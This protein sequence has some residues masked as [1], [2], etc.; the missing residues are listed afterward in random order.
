MKKSTLRIW[1]IVLAVCLAIPVVYVLCNRSTSREAT[2]EEIREAESY[3]IDWS[4]MAGW[5]DGMTEKEFILS[6]CSHDR[7]EEVGGVNQSYYTSEILPERL[8]RFGRWMEVMERQGCLY[9][10][11]LAEDDD[12]V[13]LAYTDEGIYEVCV[14]DEETDSMYHMIDG[15][16][17]VWNKFRNGFQ[18]GK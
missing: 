18:F 15:T 3:L 16:S 8:H 10:C 5:E 13:I 12:Q 7:D 2:A 9:V 17:V 4:A 11:Y 14:Y 6:L 1:L